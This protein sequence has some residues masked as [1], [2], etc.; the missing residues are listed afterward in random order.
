MMKFTA[1][2]VHQSPRPHEDDRFCTVPI[3]GDNALEIACRVAEIAARRRYGD[4]GATGFVV[5]LDAK[6]FGA[7][8]GKASIVEGQHKLTGV[9][10]KITLVPDGD[11]AQWEQENYASF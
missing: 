8:I 6:T 5:R 11:E 4:E 3:E 7:S 9:T 1:D 10:L 2:V